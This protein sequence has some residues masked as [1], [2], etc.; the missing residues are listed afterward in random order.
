MLTIDPRTMNLVALGMAKVTYGALSIMRRHLGNDLDMALVGF[1]VVLRT[2][3]DLFR[4][5][6]ERGLTEETLAEIAGERGFYTS[7]NEVATY[8]DINRATVRRKMQKLVDF[9]IL[10]KVADDKWHLKDFKHGEAVAPAL[11]LRELLENYLAVTNH[12]E[13]LLPDEV[14]PVMRKSLTE[15]GPIEAKALLDHEVEL[16]VKRKLA[17]GH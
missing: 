1:A 10:E 14:L 16:K 17:V 5:V 8:T 15:L 2:R 4:L 7:V 12:L 3:R 9:G 11:M 13:A 6:E